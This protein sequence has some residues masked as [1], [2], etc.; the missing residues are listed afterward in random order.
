MAAVTDYRAVDL[1]TAVLRNVK[2]VLLQNGG[3]ATDSDLIEIERRFRQEYAGCR[4][5][6]GAKRATRDLYEA[7]WRDVQTGMARAE[8]ARRNNCSTRTVRR[9][10]ATPGLKMAG[11]AWQS[12]DSHP[13]RDPK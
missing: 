2:A 9:A 13:F 5:Y 6:V 7:I 8:V 11:E 10:L 3:R 1:L 12:T 4:A